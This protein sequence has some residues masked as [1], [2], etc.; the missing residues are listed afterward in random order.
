M[1]PPAVSLRDVLTVLKNLKSLGL[2]RFI[3]TKEEVSKE[4]LLKESDVAKTVKGVTIAQHEEF[5]VKPA[6]LEVE[7]A[8]QADKLKKAAS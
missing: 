6:D 7:I 8:I 1:T 2:E 3:R 5:T 4:A